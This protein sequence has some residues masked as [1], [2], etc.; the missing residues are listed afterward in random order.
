MDPYSAAA[1]AAFQIA[2]G[3]QQAE[4]IKKN[5]EL[6]KLMYSINKEYADLDANE[7]LKQGITEEARYAGQIKQTVAAQNVAFAAADVDRSFG[8]AAEI[9][10]ETELIGELNKLKIRDQTH[11]KILGYKRQGLQYG[12]QSAINQSSAATQAAATQAGAFLRGASTF[13]SG[14][15]GKISTED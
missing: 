5:A 7:A 15:N 13:A 10:A 1:L 3:L 4:M 6:N 11:A 9:Q 2:T 14:Y 12:A 8:T